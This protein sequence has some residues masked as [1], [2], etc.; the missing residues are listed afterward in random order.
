MLLTLTYPAI[1]PVLVE[2][3]PFAIRWYALAYIVG[4]L[5]GWRYV[6]WLSKRSPIGITREAIDDFVVWATLGIVFG[7]RLGYILFY[8]PDFYFHHPLQAL[9]VWHGGMSFHGGLLGVIFVVW[10]FS[11]KRGYHWLGIGDLICCAA[12]IGLFFG[13]IANFINGELWGRV[14][15]SPIGMVFPGGGPLPRYPSQLIEAT[16]E[17]LVLFLVLLFFATR[18]G[19]FQRRGFLCGVFL[20]GYGIARPIGELFRQPD[21]FIGFLVDGTTM[22]Q[23]LSLPVLL[24]GLWL[25]ATARR[26]DAA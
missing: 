13:R 12:P 3:G 26:H 16:L 19:S 14:T 9:E 2:I 25:L 5:I 23:W 21:A 15:D 24:I 4:I 18:E 20:T 17:G 22:G 7:G 1:N 11:R 8:K 10:L 6:V